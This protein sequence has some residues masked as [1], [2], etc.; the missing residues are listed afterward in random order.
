MKKNKAYITGASL[1]CALGNTSHE[2][3]SALRAIHAQNYEAF[4]KKHFAQ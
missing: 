3:T 4:L 1:W 2:I